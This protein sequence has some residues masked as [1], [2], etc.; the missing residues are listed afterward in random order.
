MRGV[1]KMKGTVVSTWIKTCRKLYGN[2]IV[3]K[4]M[5]NVGWD[6]N[7]IFTPLENVEDEKIKKVINIVAKEIKEPVDKLWGELGENNILTFFNDYPAF[8][9]RNNLY[10]FLKGMNDVHSVI[11]K[12]LTERNLQYLG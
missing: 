8:F 3:D 2:E 1:K 10:T 7:R 11:M 6:K 5:N 4:A 9:N 12:K